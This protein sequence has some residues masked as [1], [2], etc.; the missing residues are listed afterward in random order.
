M[1]RAL[2]DYVDYDK[3]YPLYEHINRLSIAK[4]RFGVL[5]S[6]PFGM[7]FSK[8]HSLR[9]KFFDYFVISASS[10]KV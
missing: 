2:M 10:G 7:L 6:T 3:M 4:P 1:H 5:R 8:F 9:V